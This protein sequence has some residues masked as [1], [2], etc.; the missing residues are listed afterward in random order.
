[1]LHKAG[2]KLGGAALAVVA[3]GIVACGTAPSAPV[4]AQSASPSP[5]KSATPAPTATKTII[6][7]KTAPVTQS[8]ATA[9]APGTVPNV[10]DP[11]A[12]VA[13]YYGDVESGDYPEAWALLSSG[14][15]TGQTYQQF[16]A[17]FSCT[18]AQQLTELSDS[19]NQV[20]FS[21]AATDDCTGAV[22][23]YDGTDVV[24]NGKI[25]SADIT[26]AG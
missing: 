19:G 21:L 3:V 9:P 18:G 16:V 6:E 15:V 14:M 4:S 2:I 11:W 13:A 26:R 5:A 24:E 1:M 12:V 8:P 23:H 20:T 10:T 25:V 7:R 22:Q 17:G